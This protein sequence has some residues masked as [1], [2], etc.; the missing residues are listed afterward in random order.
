M[1]RKREGGK[2]EANAAVI[3]LL[4]TRPTDRRTNIMRTFKYVDDILTIYSLQNIY[5]YT[6]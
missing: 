2:A 5:S 6:H 3:C 1:E 4:R